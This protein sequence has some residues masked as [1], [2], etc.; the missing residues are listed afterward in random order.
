MSADLNLGIP[1]LLPLALAVAAAVVRGLDGDDAGE[2]GGPAGHLKAGKRLNRDSGR[3]SPARPRQGL[4]HRL[5]SE[6]I[7]RLLE[8]R[9]NKSDG[10]V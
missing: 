8:I 3:R 9:C 7:V 4:Q 10:I 5:S 1:P 2:L 6:E